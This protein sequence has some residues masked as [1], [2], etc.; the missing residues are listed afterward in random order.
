MN[1]VNSQ[2]PRTFKEFKSIVRS[3]LPGSRYS[4]GLRETE[5]RFIYYESEEFVITYCKETKL[6]FCKSTERCGNNLFEA[7]F[8]KA[9]GYVLEKSLLKEVIN[10]LYAYSYSLT[11]EYKDR[12]KIRRNPIETVPGALALRLCRVAGYDNYEDFRQD[13]E[14]DHGVDYFL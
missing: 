13:T 7:L 10:N 12:T 11:E 5:D 1:K 6:W 2:N 4:K 3:I 9:E 14:V 8:G